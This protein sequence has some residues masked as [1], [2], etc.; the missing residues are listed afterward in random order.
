VRA[1][2]KTDRDVHRQWRREGHGWSTF[3]DA[4]IKTVDDKPEVVVFL[5]WGRTP[6]RR[7]G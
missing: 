2:T 4:V 7:R 1:G 6:E 5:L 3:T